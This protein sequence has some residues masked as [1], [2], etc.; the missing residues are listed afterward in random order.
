ML[1]AT[2]RVPAPLALL[3]LTALTVL[4]G[5]ALVGLPAAPAAAATCSSANGV[6]VVVDGQGLTIRECASRGSGSAASMFAAVGVQMSRVTRFPDAIC[7]VEGLP[8][9]ARCDQMPPGNAFWGLFWSDGTSGWR[10][11]D[12]GVYDQRVPEGGSV[13]WVWQDGGSREYPGIA[14][15][16]HR[17]SPSQ[18]PSPSPSDPGGSGGGGSG[19]GGGSGTDGTG[20]GTDEGTSG[21]DDPTGGTDDPTTSSPTTSPSAAVGSRER[22]GARADRDGQQRDRQEQRGARDRERGDRGRQGRNAADEQIY[23]TG[24]G[25]D[26]SSDDG[27]LPLWLTLAALA[28]LALLAL[29]VLVLRRRAA[30]G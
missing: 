29:V 23:A 2:R 26:A 25:L 7:R 16:R 3:L 22:D 21:T 5:G 18:N 10:F 11:A 27:G 12:Y 4:S 30:R 20:S 19:S 15:P 13:A 17:S 24:G 6:S 28:A 1:I 8:S 9:D 14:P